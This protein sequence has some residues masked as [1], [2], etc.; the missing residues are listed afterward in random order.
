MNLLELIERLQEARAKLG[1]HPNVTVRFQLNG[2]LDD[3]QGTRIHE[4]EIESFAQPP[5]VVIS[6]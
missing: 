4:V 2:L 6:N 5:Q 1:N 3:E